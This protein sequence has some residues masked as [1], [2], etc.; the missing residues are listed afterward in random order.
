MR[1]LFSG[2]ATATPRL[3][4]LVVP[5]RRPLRARAGGGSVASRTAVANALHCSQPGNARTNK[6]GPSISMAPSRTASLQGTQ[7]SQ[8]R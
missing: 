6:G 3:L 1:I 5:P 8:T 4:P 2:V 7:P